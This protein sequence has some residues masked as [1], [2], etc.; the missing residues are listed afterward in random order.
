MAK[1]T[2]AMAK[3]FPTRVANNSVLGGTGGIS[4]GETPVRSEDGPGSSCPSAPPVP[5]R[6]RAYPVVMLPTTSTWN[7]SRSSAP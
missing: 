1:P 4:L 7:L 3:A 2:T 5:D 6:T